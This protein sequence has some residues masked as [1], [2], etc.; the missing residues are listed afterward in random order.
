MPSR[1]RLNGY[2]NPAGFYLQQDFG[3]YVAPVFNGFAV[4]RQNF[5]FGHKTR[6]G[7]DTRRFDRADIRTDFG[8][9]E[10]K[11]QAVQHNR[12]NQVSQWSRGNNGD[13]FGRMLAVE[14][15]RQIRFGDIA[16]AG[17]DHF[18]IA[19]QRNRSKTPFGI[20]A[21]FSKERLAEAY[22]K[23]YDLYPAPTRHEE[24]AQFVQADQNQNRYDKRN[25]G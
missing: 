4:D 20:A 7:G 15:E 12:Q 19:A 13:T 25:Y 3:L 1:G 2:V 24:V 18:H 21:L 17:I 6:F 9:A 14:S 23:A 22:G 10:G 5:I 16:F 8:N 11:T